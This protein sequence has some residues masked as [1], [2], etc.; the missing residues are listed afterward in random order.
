MDILQSSRTVHRSSRQ[1]GLSGYLRRQAGIWL[2]F[3]A[4]LIVASLTSAP[5]LYMITGSFK[6]NSEIF[7]YPLRFLPRETTL[8]NYM[9][10]LNGSE[11]PFIRQF[12]NSCLVS[13]SQTLLTL[14]VA[15]L[16]GWGFAKY[17]F[18]GKRVLFIFLLATLMFPFQVTLVPLFLLML[19]LGWLDTYWAIIIPGSLNAFGVFFMRQN[20]LSVPNELLD[21]ARIDGS[22]EFGIYWRIGLPLSRPALSVLGM[23]VFLNSWNDYLWPLI[24]L[25]TTE[26]FTYPIGLATLMGLYK[27]EYGMI[28]AGALLATLPIFALFIMGR[29]EFVAGLAT[30]ALKG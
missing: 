15:S 20:M 14:L 6:L 16:V 23:L 17:E 9:R 11:I 2:L 24:V 18:S 8:S 26:K 21:A 3:L 22:S 30:G 7:S 13:I 5:Y 27:I 10:L 4:L 25:R 19:S 1:A 12:L 29:N 28:L